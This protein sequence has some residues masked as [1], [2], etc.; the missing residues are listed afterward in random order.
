MDVSDGYN[1][2]VFPVCGR[3][4]VADTLEGGFVC[5]A[6]A[7]RLLKNGLLLPCFG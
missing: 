5:E 2:L 4:G 6:V 3:L 7:R 1:G